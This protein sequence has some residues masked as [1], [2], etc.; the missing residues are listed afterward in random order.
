[1]FENFKNFKNF[2]IIITWNYYNLLLLAL[3]AFITG[4]SYF[5]EYYVGLMPCL[6]C[7]IERYIILAL[8]VSCVLNLTIFCWMNSLKWLGI[9][10]QFGLVT[11]G[12]AVSARHVY[13]QTLPDN[14]VPSCV[15]SFE[16]L[17][18]QY[19]WTGLLKYIFLNSHDC[20]KENF[21]LFY[22]SLPEWILVVFIGILILNVF[23]IK[24]LLNYN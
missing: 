1:M 6:L 17:L 5:L 24:K 14:L 16:R 21:V 8:G 12:L 4:I 18:K 19:E 7:S 3:T 9:F 20:G 10:F 22:L 13:L 2:E 23:K 15:T 11:L